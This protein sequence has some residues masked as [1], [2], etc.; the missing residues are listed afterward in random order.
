[1]ILPKDIHFLVKLRQKLQQVY[2]F[3]FISMKIYWFVKVNAEG[4]ILKT[5]NS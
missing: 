5:V 2:S 4:A 3:E 1:M